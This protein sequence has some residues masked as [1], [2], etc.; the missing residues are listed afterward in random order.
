LKCAGG[1][2]EKLKFVLG[3]ELYHNNDLYWQTVIDI[4]KNTN[5]ARILRSITIM[6]RQEGETVDFA[7]LIYPP[8]Q[9]AD[10]FIQSLNIAH[11][12]L[13]QR[14]AQVIAR[15]CALSLSFSPLLNKKGKKIKPV[16][17]H[18]HL[19][20]GLGQPPVW[21][22]QKENLQEVWSALKMSK[23][24]PDT[25][26]FIH[27]SPEEIKRK[28]NKAFCPEKETEFNPVL[29][30]CKYIIF[31]IKNKLE[32]KRPEKFGGNVSYDSYKKLEKDYEEGKLHPMD[33]KNGVSEALIKILE[34]AREHFSKGKPKEMLDELEK[35]IVT[36]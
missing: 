12:G 17:I 32:I 2:P 35:L 4:S 25:C 5:L 9:V 22:V 1:N 26:I 15:D 29:D 6:G 21:P 7:K 19:L 27:D 14:K 30:W 33:L 31:Q 11:G 36:R 34:P 3:S 24:K 28:I 18:S 10:I 13:D 16:A 20:L 23:S 8:M